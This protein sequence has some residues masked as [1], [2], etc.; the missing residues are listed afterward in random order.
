MLGTRKNVGSRVP[1]N[2]D[3]LSE[4]DSSLVQQQQTESGRPR[5]NFRTDDFPYRVSQA[6][7]VHLLNVNCCIRTHLSQ[8]LYV[9]SSRY[10]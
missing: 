3:E 9:C 5:V 7:V 6:V 4:W 2:S 1:M 10:I 8:S